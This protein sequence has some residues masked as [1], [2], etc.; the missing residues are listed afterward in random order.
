VRWI[1]EDKEFQSIFLDA[2]VCVFI[3]SRREQ[4][5]LICLNFGDLET[6]M[7]SFVP[8]MHK[9]MAWAG[10]TSAYY[11]LLRPDP[12]QYFHRH[13][14]KYPAFEITLDDTAKTYLAVLNEDPGG[15]PADAV[16]TNW[17]TCVIAPPSRKWFVHVM[18]ASTDDTGHLWVPKDWVQPLIEYHP[19]LR[20]NTF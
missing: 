18:R 15:S 4:T 14:H 5:S 9:M 6:Q 1:V 19:G 3:D 20:P 13:F 2:Q 12:I 10:D 16:G 7:G 8:L 17:S 11:V